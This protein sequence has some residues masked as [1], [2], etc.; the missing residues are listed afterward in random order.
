M[1]LIMLSSLRA[2]KEACF[3]STLYSLWLNHLFNDNVRE[4]RTFAPGDK[5]ADARP[6]L[7][8]FATGWL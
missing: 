3:N 7:T 4:K 2:A 5:Q 8:R 6:K 1:Q